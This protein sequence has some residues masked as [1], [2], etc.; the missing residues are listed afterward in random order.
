MVAQV[1]DLVRVFLYGLQLMQPSIL[2]SFAYVWITSF[3]YSTLI[4]LVHTLSDT[5]ANNQYRDL[6]LGYVRFLS[7]LMNLETVPEALMNF[8]SSHSQ[9]SSYSCIPYGLI[10]FP[11]TTEISVCLFLHDI[12]N[13]GISSV[14]RSPRE[15]LCFHH[16]KQ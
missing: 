1:T 9:H 2:P 4:R 6:L 13:S 16:G 5:I 12:F 3:S 7:G 14:L 15:L 11:P 10:S 8:T